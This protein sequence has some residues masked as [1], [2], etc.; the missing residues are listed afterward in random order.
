MKTDAAVLGSPIITNDTA[1]IAG[2]DGCM[3]AVSVHTGK[4]LWRNC[5]LKGAVTSNPVLYKNALIFGSWDTY[6]YALD[7]QTGILMWK[8]S[9]GSP[10][11]NYAPAA[12]I[13]V[14]HD[15]V[16]YVVAPD[17][18]L[19]AIDFITG[20][21]LWRTKESSVRESIGISEDGKIIYAKT[22][23]DS[24]V[25]FYTNKEKPQPAWAMH[26]GFG[27]EHVPSKLI[28][29]EGKLFFGTKNGVVYCIDPRLKKI[30]WAYKIDNSM[31]NTVN[32]INGRQVIASTMDGKIA[33]LEAK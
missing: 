5:L 3:Q 29:K 26:A 24:I 9:N 28:E 17:R 32:V 13:P 15:D 33:L 8:W 2:S 18:Y 4:P 16:V 19:T 11:S 27:Y 14:V 21:P 25:A 20:N 7:R 6:L 31:V 1:Y 10:V 30:I 22:M 12:C 23:Q